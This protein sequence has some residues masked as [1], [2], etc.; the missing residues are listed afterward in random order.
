[1]RKSCICH[2]KSDIVE[3]SVESSICC[4]IIIFETFVVIFDHGHV[5][6][7]VAN[8]RFSKEIPS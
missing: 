1:M 5:T 2:S 7:C 6:F 8:T 4:S 3:A